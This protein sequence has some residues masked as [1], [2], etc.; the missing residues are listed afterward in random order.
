MHLRLRMYVFLIRGGEEL[1]LTLSIPVR[2]FQPH[3]FPSQKQAI[4]PLTAQPLALQAQINIIQQNEHLA[5]NSVLGLLLA[6][7]DLA[8]ASL[9]ATLNGFGQLITG[10]VSHQQPLPQQPSLQA[11]LQHPR[12]RHCTTHLKVFFFFNSFFFFFFFNF[13]IIFKRMCGIK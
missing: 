11:S 6:L 9:L 10:H 8:L 5:H 7:V 4:F 13:P 1:N 2:Y 12:R 3:I